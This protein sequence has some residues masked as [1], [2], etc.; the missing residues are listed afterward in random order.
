MGG[1]CAQTHVVFEIEGPA[2]RCR[3]RCEGW[4]ARARL[5][6][7]DPPGSPGDSPPA[8]PPGS[9]GLRLYL[10]VQWR[11]VCSPGGAAGC[12]GRPKIRHAP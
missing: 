11:W 5:G 1:L 9:L 4:R 6:P 2:A 7:G 3:G 10:P 12:G 8:V